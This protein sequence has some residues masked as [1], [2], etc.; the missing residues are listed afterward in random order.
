MAMGGT[1]GPTT[2]LMKDSGKRIHFLG[3][4]LTPGQTRDNT[5]GNGWIISCT[6]KAYTH[7]LTAENIMESTDRIKS[8]G[9]AFTSGLM[10]RYM[11]ASGLMG[12]STERQSFRIRRGRRGGGFGR[13]ESG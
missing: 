1:I 7:G 4:A 8:T 3:T 12:S 5:R 13:T 6:A 9:T 2:Q 10:E 11:T